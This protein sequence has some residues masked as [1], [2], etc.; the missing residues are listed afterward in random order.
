MLF[1]ECR[2]VEFVLRIVGLYE[3]MSNFMGQCKIPVSSFRTVL[4]SPTREMTYHDVSALAGLP[5]LTSVSSLMPVI[6]KCVKI[7]K[8]K[9][10]PSLEV[11]QIQKDTATPIKCD[12]V[13]RQIVEDM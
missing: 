5:L 13:T 12:H 9:L 1:A 6:I 8:E 10:T 11:S 7:L 3:V 2:E 4:S